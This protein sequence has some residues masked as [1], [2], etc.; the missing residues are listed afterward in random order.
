MESRRVVVIGGGPGGYVA[1]IRAAQLGAKVTLI[2]RD[3]IGGTCLNRGCI[4]TKSLLSDVKLLHSL[5]R[6][7]VFQSLI[8]KGFDPLK[9][10]MERKNKVVQELVKGVEMLL[11]SQ[12]VTT[13]YAQADLFGTHHV[14]LLSERNK[15]EIIE[16]DAIILAPGSVSK[17]LSDIIPNGGKIITS[18]EALEIRIPREIVISGEDIGVGTALFN[19]LGSK[20][21]LVEV[22]K[23][24][25]Q[26]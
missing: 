13:K 1:A 17:T 10:M 23:I 25:F 26:P 16:A 8:T 11:E 12:R 20:V 22:L 6:S 15:K 4:P 9:S 2:E 14:V 19:I 7:T 24:F 3:K 5:R 18:D 21:T